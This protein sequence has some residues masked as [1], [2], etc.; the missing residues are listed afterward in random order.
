M[1]FDGYEICTRKMIS[2]NIEITA[3]FVTHGTQARESNIIYMYSYNLGRTYT[4][5]WSW[6]ENRLKAEIW[7]RVLCYGN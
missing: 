6:G 1:Y 7:A 4:G 5:I 2:I 3:L